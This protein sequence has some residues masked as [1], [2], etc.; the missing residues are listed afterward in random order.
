MSPPKIVYIDEVQRDL[1]HYGG[2]FSQEGRFEIAKLRPPPKFDVS[3]ILAEK[4][5]LVLVDYELTKAQ[6]GAEPVTYM[7]GTLANRLRETIPET[8]QVL[9]TRKPLLLQYKGAV[10]QLEA[11]DFELYKDEVD[12][13]PL[14]A[15]SVLIEIV[16]G[17]DFLRRPETKDWKRLASVLGATDQEADLLRDVAPPIASTV[18]DAPPVW[19]VRLAARWILHV[20]FRYPGVL[21][22]SLFAA[23]ALGVSQTSFLHPDVQSIFLSARY[24]GPFGDLSAR[25]WIGRLRQVAYGILNQAGMQPPLAD[26]FPQALEKSH[27]LRLE[28]SVCVYSHE[29]AA[30]TVCF[31]LK[32]AV[33]RKYT[34]EYFPDGRP[35]SMET[36]RVSYRAIIEDQRVDD[37]LLSAEGRLMA[38]AI[39]EGVK[40]C[41]QQ[42]TPPPSDS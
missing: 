36:A 21:Y 11:F 23:S 24:A 10:D 13:D 33:K 25:W 18:P 8:P 4:P 38:K 6:A 28:P 1:D 5:D 14:A 26:S 35:P 17:Y 20:L 19:S 29:S 41:A 39:R 40:P 34:L 37:D 22:D 12:A 15:S 30:D 3:P 27:S 16:K 2:L 9:L 31:V 7:G 42:N 32:A